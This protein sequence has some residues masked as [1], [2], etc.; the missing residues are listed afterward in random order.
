[1]ISW[2]AVDLAY[3]AGLLDSDGSIYIR[4]GGPRLV[5]AQHRRRREMIDWVHTRFGGRVFGGKPYLTWELNRGPQ[6][7]ALLESC[8]PYLVVKRRQAWAAIQF[9]KAMN[10][11]G[12][13]SSGLSERQLLV[14]EWAQ[15]QCQEANH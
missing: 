12:G 11:W 15:R 13:R 10:R 4:R 14:R 6:I 9:V 5:I 3:M 2:S 1:M 8:Y 7:R